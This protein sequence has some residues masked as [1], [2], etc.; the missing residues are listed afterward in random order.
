MDT[1]F[2]SIDRLVDFGL[3]MTISQQM[4][5]SMNQAIQ[6]MYIP[7]SM[8]SMP[9][10]NVLYVAIEG[11]PVGPLSEGDFI[12]LI[13]TCKVT[14]ETLA[15]LPGMPSWKRIEETPEILRIIALTPPPII[16]P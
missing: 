14:K 2:Y 15:W 8:Q 4:V 13:N 10:P 1:D 11:K 5:N 7:G 6:Q 12:K 16:E 9:T 3:S